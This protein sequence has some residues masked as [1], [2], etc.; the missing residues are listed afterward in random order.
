MRAP[1]VPARPPRA[2]ASLL[3]L[4]AGT[5]LAAVAAAPALTLAARALYG[6]AYDR[7]RLLLWLLAAGAAGSV[8]GMLG[9][10]LTA[11]GVVAPQA[12]LNPLAVLFCLGLCLAGLDPAA[13][14]ALA[15]PGLAEV[16][17]ARLSR[18]RA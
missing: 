5:G 7:P 10:A 16:L 11:A 18:V 4:S 9:A 3:R 14:L 8:A 15:N 6:P 2:A 12:V 1:A 13:A 17:G